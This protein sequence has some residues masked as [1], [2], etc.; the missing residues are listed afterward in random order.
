MD[1]LSRKQ[2]EVLERESR[3]LEVALPVVIAHGYHGLSMDKIAEA[4]EYSKGTIY[5]HFP[6]KEEIILALAIDTMQRRTAMFQRASAFSG[7]PRQRMHAIGVAAELVSRLN[8]EQ[9]AVENLIRTPSI[10]DKTTAERRRQMQAAETR[11]VTTAAGVARDA[12][13]QGDLKLPADM[14]AEEF[15][16]GFWSLSMGA[17]SMI[18]TNPNLRRL[19]VEDAFAAVREHMSRL[20]DGYQWLPLSSQSDYQSLTKQV[21]NEVFGEEWKQLKSREGKS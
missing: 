16:F 6:C 9:F 4:I 11:C 10:W 2:R 19:G 13:S 21:I 5:N 1:D 18:A 12:I 3:I 17:Y 20:A 8:P 14:N 7:R 15:V